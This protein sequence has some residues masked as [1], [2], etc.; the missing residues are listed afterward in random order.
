MC[1]KGGKRG[2]QLLFP[3][4]DQLEHPGGIL[5]PRCRFRIVFLDGKGNRS[6]FVLVFLF[7]FHFN[8]FFILILHIWQCGASCCSH[9]K[10]ADQGLFHLP[11]QNFVSSSP[12][13]PILLFLL[14]C[15][16]FLITKSLGVCGV[17]LPKSNSKI[18]HNNTA[19]REGH[20][21]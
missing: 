5:H 7:F 9:R 20:I 18:C 17:F 2:K 16:Y 6:I 4:C 13:I 1:H 10:E 12:Q 11:S 15:L 3:G 8:L 19:A 21:F 14:V